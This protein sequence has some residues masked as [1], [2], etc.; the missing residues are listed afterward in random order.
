MAPQQPL[1][2]AVHHPAQPRGEPTVL[3]PLEFPSEAML[4]QAMPPQAVVPQAR[5]RPPEPPP[6]PLTFAEAQAELGRSSDREDVA[7]T[8]LRFA[9]GKWKRCLL[10]SVQGSLVTGWH[11]MGQGVRDAAVRRIGVALRDQSTFRLVRDTR[12][13]YVGPVK[14]DA[15]MA[16]FYKLVGGGFPTTA[17]ILPLLVRGKVVHLLYVDNGPDQFTTPDV[18]ELLILSQSVGRSYEAMMRRRKSA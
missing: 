7:R 15:A 5:A 14:R 2:P 6:S 12:S 11:G 18:G 9:V 8:V 17:V 4:P 10:L 3:P 13:H 16:V 1:A